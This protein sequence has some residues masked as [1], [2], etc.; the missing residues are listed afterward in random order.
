M[1]ILFQNFNLR[2]KHPALQV[3]HQLSKY[4][5]IQINLCESEL[6]LCEQQSCN[7]ENIDL[8]CKPPSGKT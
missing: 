1:F 4:V 7:N 2:R 3:P 6:F 5:Y 8:A